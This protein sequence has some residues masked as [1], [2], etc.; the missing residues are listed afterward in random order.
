MKI[1]SNAQRPQ[2]HIE[3]T[4][5]PPMEPID[6][7]KHNLVVSRV[8]LHHEQLV[9]NAFLSIEQT[10]RTEA[11]FLAMQSKMSRMHSESSG[12]RKYWLMGPWS[13]FGSVLLRKQNNGSSH[14]RAKIAKILFNCL[15]VPI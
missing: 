12:L 5:N 6:C 2:L 14:G 10:K 8:E 11:N 13:I 7:R 3:E 1:V 4:H 15:A 9:Q